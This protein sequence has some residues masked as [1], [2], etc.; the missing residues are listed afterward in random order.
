MK[1]RF[2]LPALMLFVCGCCS[3]LIAQQTS[4][5]PQGFNKKE[6]SI[7]AISA[8]TAK[9]YLQPLQTEL[10]N[11]LAA[12]LTINEIKEVL[13]HLSAYCGFPRSLQGLN[14]LITVVDNRKAQGFRD[15]Q[16]REPSPVNKEGSKYDV[17]KANL[18]ALSGQ[19]E[20]YPKTGYAAFAPVIDT[21]LKEHLF[22]DIFNRDV[23]DYR[24]R[25]LATIAALTALGGVEP[26]LQGHLRIALYLGV[27]ELELQQ[28]FSILEVRLG[29]D[30]AD[31]G[32][33]VLST[34]ANVA[35]TKGPDSTRNSNHLFAKGVQ[36][37]ANNFTGTAW[38]NMM[39]TTADGFNITVGSV[40]FEAG[41]RTAWH[42]HPKGQI[43]IITEGQGYYQER[44]QPKRIMQKGDVI[45]CPAGIEHWHGASHLNQVTH[46]AI[47]PNA[48]KGSAIWLEKVTDQDYGISR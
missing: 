42:R 27:T 22:A 44:G 6:Q 38:V 35:V 3:T 37:P 19:P 48:E 4:N 41:A 11:G 46:I 29:K 45:K 13:V 43:L 33:R 47:G 2:S 7:V 34:I 39:V 23:L 25:E 31:G 17:G 26:M 32:R 24:Q 9:G 18:E 36:A 15:V 16:G 40:T 28:I 20:R 10:A 5:Q 21:F 12:G 30:E 8:L 1:W 14:T